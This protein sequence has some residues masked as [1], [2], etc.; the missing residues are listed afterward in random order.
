[1]RS[2]VSSSGIWFPG[3]LASRNGFSFVPCRAC[4][5]FSR[6]SHGYRYNRVSEP[7]VDAFD[8]AACTQK[9]PKEN[10]H[11]KD[12]V[13]YRITD[14]RRLR[15]R[16][17]PSCAGVVE[18]MSRRTAARRTRTCLCIASAFSCNGVLPCASARRGSRSAESGAGR[19][20]RGRHTG[21]RHLVFRDGSANAGDHQRG[22]GTTDY[23]PDT[24]SRVFGRCAA[25]ASDRC[26]PGSHHDLAAARREAIDVEPVERQRSIRCGSDAGGRRHGVLGH[27]A[28]LPNLPNVRVR[29]VERHG[30]RA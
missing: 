30:R 7:T 28:A 20:R 24:A 1:M 5:L 15:R 22:W 21:R 18:P 26:G 6:R 11:E 27:G 10:N 23:L 19:P 2:R 4:A 29:S 12:S 13:H 17:R 25:T 3:P 8:A 9:R 16:K 14:C